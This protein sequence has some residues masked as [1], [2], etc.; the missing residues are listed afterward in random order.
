VR[1]GEMEGGQGGKEKGKG[2]TVS[3]YVTILLYCTSIDF[4]MSETPF[5]LIIAFAR[6][7]PPSSSPSDIIHFMRAYSA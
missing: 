5:A 1:I 7:G 2:R 4:R 6:S 3:G